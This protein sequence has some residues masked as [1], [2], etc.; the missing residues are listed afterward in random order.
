MSVIGSVILTHIVLS[1]L[2]VVSSGWNSE[3]VPRGPLD[4]LSILY[5]ISERKLCF[6]KDRRGF[7]FFDTSKSLLS[8]WMGGWGSKESFDF[9]LFSTVISLKVIS[10]FFFLV[11][12]V[13]LFF[14]FQLSLSISL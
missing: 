12:G 2:T 6:Q 10:L 3:A 5:V 8:G 4:S 13:K 14:D 9:L 11:R 7:I 1:H